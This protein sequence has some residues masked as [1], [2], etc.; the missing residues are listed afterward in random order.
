MNLRVCT[1]ILS[2]CPHLECC[3]RALLEVQVEPHSPLGLS[4]QRKL[5]SQHFP[6]AVQVLPAVQM[7]IICLPSSVSEFARAVPESSPAHPTDP[8]ADQGSSWASLGC[9][10]LVCSGDST[11]DPVM[12]QLGLC[13]ACW[14]VLPQEAQEG[15][16]KGFFQ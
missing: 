3:G 2:V 5:L 9:P 11:G 6:F 14:L 8:T 12:F 4:T 16:E 7:K 15:L 10:S 13:D 1:W